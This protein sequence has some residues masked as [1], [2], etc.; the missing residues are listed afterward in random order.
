MKSKKDNSSNIALSCYIILMILSCVMGFVLLGRDMQDL[1]RFF[2]AFF[3]LSMI[4]MP[5]T[6]R[7]LSPLHSDG[8]YVIGKS[9]GLFI[10]SYLQFFL[11]T[12]RI[13]KFSRA[14]SVICVIL[15][16]CVIWSVA[17]LLYKK[18]EKDK[19]DWI[20]KAL[21]ESSF[22]IESVL[23]WEFVVLATFVIFTWFLGQ[24]IPSTGTERLMNYGM[25]LTMDKADH[26][27]ALDMWF[28]G[29]SL[30]YYYFGQ[31]MMTY[32]SKLSFT[33]VASAYSLSLAFIGATCLI[34]SY[35]IV[36]S[37][38]GLNK[39]LSDRICSI[40]GIVGALAVTCCGNA[41]YIV[42]NLIS[43]VLRDILRLDTEYEE[44]F[45][46]HSTRYIGYCPVVE[47]DKTITEFPWYSFI[48]GDLHAHVIDIIAVLTVVSILICTAA[49]MDDRS[50]KSGSGKT[51]EHDPLNA[52][53]FFAGLKGEFASPVIWIIGFV[54]GIMAMT[55]YWDLPI[56][57][58]VAGSI[59]LFFNIRRYEKVWPALAMT[60]VYGIAIYGIA[61]I[62][63]LPFEL[64]FYKFVNGIK[65][66]EYHSRLYQWLILWGLPLAVLVTFVLFLCIADTKD[67][68]DDGNSTSV[69]KR[70]QPS[71][72]F[73]LL[74]G[75]CAIGLALVPEVI[76]VEDIYIN[77]FPRCNTMFK[78]TYQA[79]ILS[80][81]MMSYC[82]VRVLGSTVRSDEVISQIRSYRIK[83]TMVFLAVL[84][85]LTLPYSITSTKM[86]YGEIRD[87]EYKG[88]DATSTILTEMGQ[89]AKVLD[90]IEE[91]I[92]GQETILTAA[93][94]SYTGQGVIAALSG[95]PTVVGWRT[96]EW[97]WHND[98]DRV[99]A[100]EDDVRTIYTSTDLEVV[101]A[102][103]NKYNISYI[104]VGPTEYEK[105]G[106][107]DIDLLSELG[108]VVYRDNDIASVMIE[109]E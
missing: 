41:H 67:K 86:W 28:A 73:V 94:D 45:F 3:A 103:V 106:Q 40:G 89:E 70:L 100:R 72:L 26:L 21:S 68:D 59:I 49:L 29:E 93:A 97:L 33:S 38:L 47:A 88:I 46:T 52:K 99:L 109:C 44:Y 7:F 53:E 82:I 95:H 80:G 84:L 76:F 35:V 108:R 55:N 87:W 36:S 12:V 39:G 96:H 25:M 77:G 74:T 1:L 54:L 37:L 92:P 13:L 22:S 43:P 32:L 16:G 64:R 4:V 63:K 42:F 66:C 57:Y 5:L 17:L 23:K 98:G 6:K 101:K 61:F 18:S 107:V 75:L 81:L 102:L 78:L 69:I 90:F 60:A 104:Y 65:L 48:I 34:F 9:V 8:G 83:R 56:Y 62:V 27:P 30:N 85:A 14:V 19:K 58:V 50:G 31:Y 71:D 24:K 51:G 10:C 91:N 2:L 15:A 11:S 105:Y 20:G 79:F